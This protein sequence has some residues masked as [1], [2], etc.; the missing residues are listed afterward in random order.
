MHAALRRRDAAGWRG[1]W[2][3]RS[4]TAIAWVAVAVM[5]I[6]LR[7]DPALMVLGAG[8]IAFVAVA[9]AFSVWNSAGIWQPAGDTVRD[10]VLIAA[11]RC[12]RDLRA[13]RFGLWF[14][15]IETI[16]LVAWLFWTS[17]R[18]VL[19]EISGL[20]DRWLVLPVAAP[21][22]IVA[23]L[24]LLRRRARAS[25]RRSTPHAGSLMRSSSGSRLKAQ[26]SSKTLERLTLERV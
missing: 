10:F 8:I 25:W 16:L 5:L 4:S 21:C 6:R 1:G 9:C 7:P 17:G 26:G 3:S 11:E 22:A 24:L 23:W 19:P 12:R 18:D 20:S 13:V 15:A 14:A 2:R